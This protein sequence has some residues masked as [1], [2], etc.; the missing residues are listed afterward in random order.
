M[1]PM[2]GTVGVAPAN[3]EVRSALVPDAHGGNM[4]TPE[5]RAGVTCYLGVN[6]EGAL[7]S[8]GDGHARQGEG[9]TC[10]VAVECAMNTVVIVELLK[11]L[12]TPWPRI[13]SDT[14]IISTGSAR[15]LEDAFRISQ[16]DLVQWLVRDYG[17]SELDAYQFAT[18]AVES[19]LANVCDTNYT[20]VAK[21]RKEWLPARE[22][23][24]GVHDRLRETAVAL[25]G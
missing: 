7:L 2:H 17:F 24:R 4:D 5:M 19:P 25:L 12:A 21:I 16:L 22:T 13:E 15:P 23:H 8:L 10:G 11:G 9:E 1:D 3:L 14:H 6:V 20:C 18:Q